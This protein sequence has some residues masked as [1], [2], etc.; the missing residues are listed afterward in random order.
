MVAH[1]AQQAPQCPLWARQAPSGCPKYSGLLREI[2]RGTMRERREAPASVLV[3][4]ALR[5]TDTPFSNPARSCSLSCVPCPVLGCPKFAVKAPTEA[6]RPSPGH[7]GPAG[8][9]RRTTCPHKEIV[10]QRPAR[11]GQERRLCAPSLSPRPRVTFPTRPPSGAP[12]GKSHTHQWP[13]REHT[14]SQLRA[15][16]TTGLR[17]PPTCARDA[18]PGGSSRRLHL[19]SPGPNKSDDTLGR[20]SQTWGVV[21]P[22]HRLARGAR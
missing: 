14:A 20:P 9:A 10:W 17:C 5:V 12:L 7:G 2:R 11:Q 4:R 13:V 18:I 15:T 8:L 16:Q 1:A 3:P 19:A 21:P 22:L 6:G